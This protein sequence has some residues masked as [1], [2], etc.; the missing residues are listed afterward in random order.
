MI[1]KLLII[2]A[3][4]CFAYGVIEAYLFLYFHD[5]PTFLE[6]LLSIFVPF[7]PLIL[8]YPLYKNGKIIYVLVAALEAFVLWSLMPVY[9]W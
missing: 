7:L 1:R 3:A 4:V 9:S 8:M 5:R 6:L 2:V